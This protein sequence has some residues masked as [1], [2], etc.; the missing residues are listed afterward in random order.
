M[1]QITVLI[2]VLLDL[3]GVVVVVVVGGGGGGGGGGCDY[4]SSNESEP[5]FTGDP[6]SCIICIL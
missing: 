6:V 1:L 4:F 5:P 3:A 2:K